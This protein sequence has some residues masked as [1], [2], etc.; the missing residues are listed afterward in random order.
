M[1]R[2]LYRTLGTLLLGASA[3]VLSTPDVG[4]P[5]RELRQQQKEQADRVANAFCAAYYACDCVDSFPDHETEAECRTLISQGLTQRL[6]QGINREL[7]YDPEC[8]EANVA[9]YE[10]I[11]CTISR[12]LFETDELLGLLDLANEAL[13]CRT[14]HGPLTLNEEC[15]PLATARGGE[16]EPGLACDEDFEMCLDISPLPE[17]EQCGDNGRPCGSGLWCA[18]SSTNVQFTCK[19][20]ATPGMSCVD[21]AC[22]L[23]SWCDPTDFIC[24]PFPELGQPCGGRYNDL[25]GPDLS[26]NEERQCVAAAA[27]GASCVDTSCGS[28]LAC[29]SAERCEAVPAMICNMEPRLP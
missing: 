6:E 17:G 3:C 14:Y 12:Q 7:E 13:Q 19:P 15:T 27:E 28:G 25:C 26:C 10:E 23:G 5:L 20:P 2:H 18:S 21:S 8:L 29:G 1:S 24:H 4:A 11:G 9:F 16:C 22:T